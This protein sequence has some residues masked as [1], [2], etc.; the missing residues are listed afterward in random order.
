MI[1]FT[2]KIYAG[3]VLESNRSVTKPHEQHQL[4]IILERLKNARTPEEKEQVFGDL[5][6]MPHLFAA[7]IKM[8]GNGDLSQ[9]IFQDFPLFEM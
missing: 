8:K 6:K 1:S 3:Q 9:V 5:K 2:E 4:Q 7:F